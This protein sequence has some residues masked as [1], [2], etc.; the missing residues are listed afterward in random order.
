MTTAF[1]DSLRSNPCPTYVELLQN[2]HR[3]LQRNGFRQL[4][5]LSSSQRFDVHRPFLLEDAVPNSNQTIGRIVRKKFRAQRRRKYD[6]NLNAM[7]GIGAGGILG[8]LLLASL[9]N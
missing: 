8:G 9:I 1:C 3:I 5:Q 2:I 4:P 7:L 6:D